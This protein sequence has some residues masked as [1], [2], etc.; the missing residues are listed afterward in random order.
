M[1]SQ[2]LVKLAIDQ[3]NVHTPWV[4]KLTL[5]TKKY[6]NCAVRYTT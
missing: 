6:I 1:P 2:I 3:C 4:P 5:T